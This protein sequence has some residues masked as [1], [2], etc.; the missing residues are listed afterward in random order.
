MAEKFATMQ[1]ANQERRHTSRRSRP[2]ELSDVDFDARRLRITQA[3]TRS[4]QGADLRGEDSRHGDSVTTSRSN[5]VTSAH[6]PFSPDASREHPFG[7]LPALIVEEPAATEST[8]ASAPAPS[9]PTSPSP[10]LPGSFPLDHVDDQYSEEV[11]IE[12][13][14]M[15]GQRLIKLE[16]S[17]LQTSLLQNDLDEEPCSAVTADTM[18]TEGT[19]IEPEP[20]SEF[21]RPRQHEDTMFEH[22]MQLRRTSHSS[23]NTSSSINEDDQVDDMAE[24]ESVQ[25]MLRNPRISHESDPFEH[26]QLNTAETDQYLRSSNHDDVRNS[27]TSSIQD[28]SHEDDSTNNESLSALQSTPQEEATPSQLHTTA[29]RAPIQHDYWQGLE[30]ETLRSTMA[31][32]AYTIVNFVLQQNSLS[33]IVDANLAD[34]IYDRVL[35]HSPTLADDG[36]LDSQKL[37]Q[38]AK[39]AFAEYHGR[40]DTIAQDEISTASDEEIETDG[41]DSDTKVQA[42][43]PNVSEVSTAP[44]SRT[45]RPSYLGHRQKASLDSAEDW[46]E[47]SPSVGDWMQFATSPTSQNP[48]N[49]NL[50]EA[51]FAP[52]AQREWPQNSR[53]LPPER[54]PDDDVE[55]AKP[56]AA[57]RSEYDAPPPPSK[58]PPLP[59]LPHVPFAPQPHA[60]FPYSSA[61][62][63]HQ[64]LGA[65]IAP[66]VPRRITSLSQLNGRSS[67]DGPWN[68]VAANDRPSEERPSSE[69][70]SID[71]TSERSSPSPEE[72]QL[73]KRRHILGEFVDTEARFEKDMKV[74][75]DIYRETAYATLS[76]D[77]IKILFGN[78]NQV[79]SFVTDFLTALKQAAKPTYVVDRTER[80]PNSK[81]RMD[82]DGRESQMSDSSKARSDTASS[83][84]SRAKDL[85]KDKLTHV[86]GTFQEA[87]S[88]MGEVYAEYIRNH[89]AANK[90]LQSV[91]KIYAVEQWLKECRENS[92]DL[93]SAW[94]LDSL[95]VKPVQRIMKYPLLLTQLIEA[96]PEDHPDFAA[97]KTSFRLVTELNA[98]INETKKQA[99][100]VEQALTRKR[101]ESDVRNGLSKALGRRTEK[102]RQQV[103]I[104]EMF[105]DREYNTLKVDF[106]ENSSHLIV[107]NRD[108][109]IYQDSVSAWVSKMRDLAAV[110][111]AWAGVHSSKENQQALSKLHHFSHLVQRVSNIALPDHVLKIR[112]TVSEPMEKAFKLLEGLTNDPKGL[113]QKRDKR[114]IDYAR[115]KNMRDRGEKLDR[116]TAERIEQWE[117]L[118]K[119]AKLRIRKL[120]SLTQQ[121]VQYAQENYVRHHLAWLDMCNRKFSAVMAIDLDK[122]EKVDIER[123]WQEEFDFHHA[124]AMSMSICNGA[125]LADAVNMVNMLTP[126]SNMNGD[127][128]P[129]QYPWTAAN[130][131]SISINSESSPALHTDVTRRTSGS[132]ASSTATYVADASPSVHS[133]GRLRAASTTSTRAPRTPDPSFRGVSMPVRAPSLRPS[134][135][136]GPGFAGMTELPRLSVDAVS[137]SLGIL[138]ANTPAARPSSEATFVS[139]SGY[140]PQGQNGGNGTGPQ[141]PD[142]FL[143]NDA[144]S[145]SPSRVDISSFVEVETPRRVLFTA[146][147]VYE[148]NID[149]SRRE[150]GFPYLQ[151]VAGEIFDIFDERG[152]LWLARNQDDPHATTGWIWNKHFAKLAE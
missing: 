93:T 104:S 67:F 139:A 113:L 56:A 75:S 102:L 50:V 10:N 20:Q 44:S 146:A 118:N 48:S 3:L 62:S 133:N 82:Q 1:R 2:P 25:I 58:S 126:S 145:D 28:D 69:R 83:Q 19:T 35:S 129:R 111:V 47:T 73:K 40:Q 120:L 150:S 29:K 42:L 90:K 143:G 45:A 108:I 59:P 52:S 137:P 49:G 65:S 95:L 12:D 130:K 27:W 135:S 141:L 64:N 84:L 37:E 7:P 124:T 98:Q 147:S 63:P 31:S 121:L 24:Q 112:K 91:Q 140:V 131:R 46:A 85:E 41:E 127:E 72:R 116:R 89:D 13:S 66:Q 68:V 4:R 8:A 22:I 81:A 132:I 142:L 149:R 152:E 136:A 99:E 107:V 106:L 128:S 125:L 23:P 57:L 9:V 33:G 76:Q 11:E 5:S 39:E 30:P 71:T 21:T 105:E 122:L 34:V 109:Q 78:A 15:R 32:D 101:K 148:F 117:A 88:A 103:G 100:L 123:E 60:G 151:Y 51:H 54:P 74:L 43:V 55:D 114:L 92:S 87:L 97:L 70:P 110:G 79:L 18:E 38:L 138:R 14:R 115:Y 26:V 94:D 16:T 6:H 61:Q 77:D 17:A 36:T 53:A 80:Y 119:E 96:T 134:T 86:G 144:V